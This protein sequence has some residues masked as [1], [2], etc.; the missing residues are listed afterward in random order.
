MSWVNIFIAAL[1][2][3]GTLL[4]A[5]IAWLGLARNARINRIRLVK[6][7]VDQ[8][9]TDPSSRHF[10][11]LLDW[12]EPSFAMKVG[13][14][15]PFRATRDLVCQTLASGQM[16]GVAEREL[17]LECIDSGLVQ[18]D[19]IAKYIRA[20]VIRFTDVDPYLRFYMKRLIEKEDLRAAF[21]AY[22]RQFPFP[23]F[24]AVFL[25]RYVEIF[26]AAA[27][28]QPDQARA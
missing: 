3:L 18:L 25:A 14:F 13:D 24:E 1:S 26:A 22:M 15:E 7:L 19:R 2:T 23:D 9:R 6:E 16:D 27:R 10:F 5:G 8:I 4:A 21:E 11:K 12:D 17:L 20:G 28:L